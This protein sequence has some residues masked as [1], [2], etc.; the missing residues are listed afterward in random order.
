[1][2]DTLI[3]ALTAIAVALVAAMGTGPMGQLDL[4]KRD[5]VNAVTAPSSSIRLPIEDASGQ[6]IGHYVGQPPLM[7][8]ENDIPEIFRRAIVAVEDRR[9]GQH[10]GVDPLAV[11]AALLSTAAGRPRG[12]STLSQQLVKNKVI[13][14]EFSVRRKLIEAILSV[15]L[16]RSLPRDALLDAYTRGV[17]FGRGITGAA[18]AANA[19]F[20]RSWQDLSLDE[21]AFLAGLPQ[22][23]GRYETSVG[24]V[25]ISEKARAR[26]DVVLSAMEREGLID[27]KTAAA[28]RSALTIIRDELTKAG[29]DAWVERA[30][31]REFRTNDALQ[32]SLTATD[33]VISSTIDP[34]LQTIVRSVAQDWLS[35]RPKG[36]AGRITYNNIGDPLSLRLLEQLQRESANFVLPSTKVGRAILLGPAKGKLQQNEWRVLYVIK[37]TV[38]EETIEV[39]KV[40]GD[41]PA[42]AGQVYPCK[43]LNASCALYS[44]AQ[45]EISIVAMEAKTG[46]I[47]ASLG[48]SDSEVSAF[49]RT[50]AARQPGSA[51]KPFL[52][53]SA[54]ESGLNVTDRVQRVERSYQ[55]PNGRVW[56]PRDF[57]NEVAG[58]TISLE[59]GLVHSSNLAALN[60]AERVG[61]QRFAQIIEMAG[62]SDQANIQSEL[63]S[64][65]GSFE[66]NLVRLVSGYALLANG[67]YPV[68]PHLVAGFRKGTELKL[69]TPATRQPLTSKEHVATL[70]RILQDVV[71]RGTAAVAFENSPVRV[72]GK[73]GTTDAYRDAWFVGFSSD[74][75]IGIWIGRDDGASLSDQLTGGTAAARVGREIFQAA[76]HGGLLNERGEFLSETSID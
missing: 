36:P 30:V 57:G 55:L 24:N 10:V 17:W 59:E 32:T 37:G 72:A 39:T 27:S 14:D 73:T 35:T 18:S 25:G 53:L 62:I 23:A 46:R 49:D 58:G 56:K 9:L 19:W 21:I 43:I 71:S 3:N 52:W 16:T 69:G 2:S 40:P 41:I 48:G 7:G 33:L 67:G 11:V 65:L 13:G 44:V 50:V 60:L 38:L 61:L 5:L 20:G 6:I 64:S 26:R 15:R 29:S 75:V 63:S 1:M 42:Q 45:E 66:T 4:P 74:I 31:A 28:G 51:I 47:L 12:G 68:E 34:N 8:W 54:L 22:G 70:N 76:L